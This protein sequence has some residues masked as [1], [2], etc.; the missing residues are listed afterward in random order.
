MEFVY[1][2]TVTANLQRRKRAQERV[3]QLQS[4]ATEAWDSCILLVEEVGGMGETA[5]HKSIITKG[6][7]DTAISVPLSFTSHIVRHY[8]ETRATLVQFF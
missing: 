1:L 2:H 7:G 8:T 6:T 4:K 5:Q 3:Q